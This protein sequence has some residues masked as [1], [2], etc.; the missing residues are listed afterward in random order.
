VSLTGRAIEA[1][2]KP[3]ISAE[4]NMRGAIIHFA[5]KDGT[6]FIS[7]DDGVRY[8]FKGSEWHADG[9]PEAGTAVDFVVEAGAAK[10]LFRIGK[11]PP[12]N[13]DTDGLYKSSDDKILLGVCAGIAHKFGVNRTGLRVLTFL[14]CLFLWVPVFIYLGLGIILK[15][16]PTRAGNA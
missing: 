4:E 3:P 9:F 11:A 13:P 14:L 8:E 6:G 15:A 16:K 2:R 7:G 12:E 5:I 1:A 10:N